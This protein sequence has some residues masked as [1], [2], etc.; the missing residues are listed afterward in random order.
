MKRDF[1]TLDEVKQSIKSFRDI[2]IFCEYDECDDTYG[3]DGPKKWDDSLS[4]KELFS[5]FHMDGGIFF[6]WGENEY[7]Y[8]IN[9]KFSDHVLEFYLGPS[10]DGGLNDSYGISEFCEMVSKLILP[11]RN[12]DMDWQ[13]SENC[14]EVY[15]KEGFVKTDIDIEL[16]K[17]HIK[18]VVEFIESINTDIRVTD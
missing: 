16:A 9:D 3:W 12:F 1:K 5:K 4:D 7:E 15:S 11:E 6:G 18:D 8:L 13:A 17:K 14:G 10:D 2:L